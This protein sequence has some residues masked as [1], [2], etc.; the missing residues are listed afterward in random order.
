M[1]NK[2]FI[3]ADLE[4]KLVT[5]QSSLQGVKSSLEILQNYLDNDFQDETARKANSML[6][7]IVPQVDLII[8]EQETLISILNK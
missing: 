6:D 8:N 7:V 2:D 3:Y 4:T 1:D 5:I